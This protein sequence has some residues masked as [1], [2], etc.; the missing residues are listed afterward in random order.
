M[1]KTAQASFPL[2]YE[3]PFGADDVAESA[4]YLAS[5]LSKGVSG[6]VIYV[7]RGLSILGAATADES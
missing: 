5:P 2:K 7:D 4:L 1:E 6:Q 3:E